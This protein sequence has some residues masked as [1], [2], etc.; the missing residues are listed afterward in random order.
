MGPG[1]LTS[2]KANESRCFTLDPDAHIVPFWLSPFLYRPLRNRARHSAHH[3]H[4]R[5]R[6]GL[7]GGVLVSPTRVCSIK[8]GALF[9][10]NLHGRA[11]YYFQPG[12]VGSKQRQLG[13]LANGSYTPFPLPGPYNAG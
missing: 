13:L 10:F 2:I 4:R 7:S 8:P 12:T 6:W 9:Q 11:I 5:K 1:R 3:S